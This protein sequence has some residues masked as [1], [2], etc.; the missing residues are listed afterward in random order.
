MFINSQL[1]DWS[2][3]LKFLLFKQIGDDVIRQSIANGIRIFSV[4]RHSTMAEKRRNEIYNYLQLLLHGYI[5]IEKIQ[6]FQGEKYKN[7]LNT[8]REKSRQRSIKLD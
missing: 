8:E 6:N 5:I 1:I 7:C 4:W 3:M 2:A